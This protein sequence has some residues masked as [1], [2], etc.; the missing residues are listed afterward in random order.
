MKPNQPRSRTFLAAVLGAISL[1]AASSQ[2]VAA[3]STKYPLTV[4]NCGVSVTFDKPPQ[5]VVSI[6]Q[7][8]TEILLSLGLAPK[9]VGTAVWFGPVLPQFK[10]QN[11]KIPRLADN[12]PS[13]ESVV[14]QKP[15]LVTAEYEWHVGP[16][17]IVG[18]RPQFKKLGISTYVSPSDCVGKDNSTGGD[19]TRTR[20]FTMDLVYREIHQLAAIFDVGDRGDALVA[21]LKAREAAARKLAGADKAHNTPVMFWFSSKQVEGDAFVAGRTGVPAYMSKVLGL[22]NIIES[23]DEWPQVGWEQIAASDPSVIVIAK[24]SR[25]RYAADDPAVKMKFLDTD[26]V[27]S[28][29]QAVRTKHLIVLSAQEMDPSIRVVDGI[30]TLAESI[31]KFGLN[32]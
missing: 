15:D 4:Q 28:Q 9:M 23:D 31:K 20:M 25:R 7:S 8:S 26:P 3:E 19:G 10:E 32:K 27:A 5:R 13:F 2:A 12:D 30:E 17:G 11:A 16:H 1:A 21:R 18:T 14:K 22:T 6:G 24:M 29:L